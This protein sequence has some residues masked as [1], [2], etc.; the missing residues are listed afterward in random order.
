VGGAGASSRFALKFVLAT[1]GRSRPGPELLLFEQYRQR[2][3]GSLQIC[4]VEARRTLSAADRLLREAE[5]LRAVIPAG[6]IVVA[7]DESGV[8]FDSLAFAH[9]LRDWRDGGRRQIAFLI[10]GAD[11]LDSALKDSADL[12]LAFGA[13][14]WPHLLVRALL[15]EQIYRAECILAGHPYHRGSH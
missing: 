10:G 8:A 9:Q 12:R 14:T 4:E 5:R 3:S 7:L 15:L 11:G 2:L 1:V 13:M 6:A